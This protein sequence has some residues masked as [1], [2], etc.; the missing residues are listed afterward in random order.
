MGRSKLPLVG[1]AAV[2][3]MS[4]LTGTATGRVRTLDSHAA[5]RTSQMQ[6]LVGEWQGVATRRPDTDPPVSVRLRVSAQR[7]DSLFL[8]L[9]LPE[10]RQIALA[11][12]SP[13]S[14]E[15]VGR[16]RGDSVHVEFTADIG[17]G[18]I[19]RLVPPDSERIVLAG[20]VRNDAIVGT[21]IITR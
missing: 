18:F 19:G 11:V 2:V 7:A 3:S 21:V 16:F 5:E 10:S 14:N 1:A 17:L 6:S 13:Y 20:R 12:P 9:T 8:D 4:A 15:V